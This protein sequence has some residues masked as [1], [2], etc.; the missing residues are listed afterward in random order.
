MRN[1]TFS[2]SP[3]QGEQLRSL[4][5]Y[6]RTDIPELIEGWIER[7]LAD[8]GLNAPEPAPTTVSIEEMLGDLEL[9]SDDLN[10][11]VI[12]DFSELDAI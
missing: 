1:E 5:R 9:G 3:E 7:A 2:V 6:H 4:A 12:E 8:A 11:A 10:D